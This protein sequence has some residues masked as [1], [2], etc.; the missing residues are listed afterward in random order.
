MKPLFR[1]THTAFTLIEVLV[2]LS[3]IFLLAS[4]LLPTLG[5]PHRGSGGRI[6][7]VNN[8]KQIGTAFRVFASDNDDHYPLQ[9][10]NNS[11]ILQPDALGTAPGA[12][13][14][15]A[16]QAWQVYQAMWNELQ[17]P[18]VLLCPKDRTRATYNRVI[19]FNGL[20]KAPGLLTQASLGDP[21]NQNRAVSYAVQANADEARPQG[22]LVLDRNINF[23]TDNPVTLADTM[24]APSGSRFAITSVN[25]GRAVYWV[26]GRGSVLHDLQGNFAFADGS[27]QQAMSAVL[28]TALTNAGHSYGW[29]TPAKPGAG[30]SVFLMP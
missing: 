22:I 1:K 27:V 17:S 26:F 8:Q 3:I 14:S 4:I 29:G 25:E 28:Q 20:A 13:A 9:A 18:K 2:V 7:C 23:A 6:R 19:D 15:P 12:V 16:A 10:T 11:Y 21:S 24:A 5:K 30:A